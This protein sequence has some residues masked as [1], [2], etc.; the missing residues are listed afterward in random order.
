ARRE[1]TSL[2]EYATHLDIKYAPLEIVDAHRL[3]EECTD[4]WY[5]QTLCRVND[6]VARLGVLKGEYHWHQHDEDEFFF[7]LEGSLLIDIDDRTVELHRWTGI[8]VPRGV[9]HRPRAPERV[10]VLMFETNAVVPTG[11]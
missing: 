10:V 5:N 1:E 8:T 3:V 9:E 6:S 2:T 7:V 4:D 11:N